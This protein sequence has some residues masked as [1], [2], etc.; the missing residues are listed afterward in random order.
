MGG[1][2][3]ARHPTPAVR[4][5]IVRPDELGPTEVD[6]WAALQAADPALGNPFLRPEV[7]VAVGRYRDDT[8]VAVLEDG[9][10]VVGFLPFHR[11]RAGVGQALGLGL[12]DTQ[13]VV[14]APGVP[15]DGPTLRAMTGLAVWEFDHLVA[16]QAHALGAHPLAFR[17]SPVVDLADG[18]DAWAERH[19]GSGRLR[20]VRKSGRWLR[21]RHDVTVELHSPVPDDLTTLLRWKSDQYRRTG[22]RDLFSRPPVIALVEELVAT[23][24][25]GF[26]AHLTALRI[27]GEPAAFGLMLR[28]GGVMACWVTAYDRRFARHGPGMVLLTE[29][30]PLAADDGVTLL[31]MGVGDQDYKEAVQDRTLPMAIGAVHGRGPASLLY[32][33]RTA[34]PRMATDFVLAHPRLRAAVRDGLNR[35]GAL[36]QRATTRADRYRRTKTTASSES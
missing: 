2:D 36:R 17:P 9:P 24:T 6:R 19:A 21:R 23:H 27:D 32:R 3:L 15:W 5:T 11:G 31:D 7:A 14:L 16:D 20:T 12:T 26:R 28:S 13:G 29:T 22:R 4:A 34:P 30:F 33:A 8:R 10:N 1:H 25:D 35:A 18:A